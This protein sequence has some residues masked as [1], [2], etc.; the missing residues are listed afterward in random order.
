MSPSDHH[1]RKFLSRRSPM[2]LIN[3]RSSITPLHSIQHHAVPIQACGNGTA[4]VSSSVTTK[5]A[6]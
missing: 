4:P 2:G 5:R 6:W 1:Q 3:R